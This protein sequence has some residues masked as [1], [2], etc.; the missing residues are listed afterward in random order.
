M[1]WGPI[2]GCCLLAS[3]S[4]CSND[5][6][7]RLQA[8]VVGARADGL[9]LTRQAITVD[10]LQ[11]LEG[12]DRRVRVGAH[13]QVNWASDG[14]VGAPFFEGGHAPYLDARFQDGAYRANDLDGLVMLSF[15]AHAEAAHAYFRTLGLSTKVPEL[16]QTNIE[17]LTILS[18]ATGRE[19]LL[20]D[21]AGFNSA[22]QSFLIARQVYDT[23][24]VPYAASP[25]VVAHEFAHAVTEQLL[26]G[27]RDQKPPASPSTDPER[28]MFDAMQEGLSDLYASLFTGLSYPIPGLQIGA[29]GGRRDLGPL[30]VYSQ[31]M[32]QMSVGPLEEQDIYLVGD[33][34]AG[35]IWAYR[36][37]LI[38]EGGGPEAASLQVGRMAFEATRLLDVTQPGFHIATFVEAF[39]K[40][41]QVEA[42]L[43]SF[44]PLVHERLGALAR[45]PSCPP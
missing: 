35:L 5:E 7:G 2:F 9:M 37:Q 13:L 28:F 40:Q 3:L 25:G 43:A 26:V 10:S 23:E 17:Y 15:Y 34:M 24:S 45:I 33:V 6:G 1:R 31:E 22:T 42:S 32:E 20:I 38:Q 36:E 14:S 8:W 41:V 4:A 18:T 16:P 27:S 44:C 11:R 12:P 39:A 21:N 30:V 19:A 29:P